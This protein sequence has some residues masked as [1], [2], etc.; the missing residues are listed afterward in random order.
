MDRRDF[1]TGSMG[2][3]V[4]A[5]LPA[6][7][8]AQSGNPPAPQTW[9]AGNVRHILPTVS[10][11]RMLIKASFAQPLAGPPTLRIGTTAVRGRMND[12]DGAYW[13]FYASGLQPGQRYSL[14][15]VAADGKALC[16][17]WDL[18]TFPAADSRPDR[19]RVL[20]G[21]RNKDESWLSRN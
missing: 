8:F 2:A 7:T 4:L 12:T 1:L 20:F 21:R 17:P 16:Q 11:T 3:A 18:S 15:L 5:S 6:D 14:S 13:Q 9:D 10:D 19:F